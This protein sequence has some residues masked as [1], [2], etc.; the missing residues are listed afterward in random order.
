MRLEFERR[1][2]GGVSIH[3]EDEDQKGGMDQQQ[4]EEEKE[5]EEEGQ[6]SWWS[7]NWEEAMREMRR[8]IGNEDKDGGEDGRADD[9]DTWTVRMR[10][11]LG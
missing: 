1:R 10:A 2:G 9:E 5:E 7:G 4:E 3:D 6:R 11:L 8:R